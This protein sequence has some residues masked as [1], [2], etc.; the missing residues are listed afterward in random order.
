MKIENCHP[1]IEDRID[2][3][4]FPLLEL[5]NKTLNLTWCLHRYVT[6]MHAQLEAASAGARSSKWVNLFQRFLS[7]SNGCFPPYSKNEHGNHIIQ[8]RTIRTPSIVQKKRW[9]QVILTKL[10][11]AFYLYYDRTLLLFSRPM[12]DKDTSALREIFQYSSLA[13]KPFD[14]WEIVTHRRPF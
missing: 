7:G 11:S 4:P 9:K 14:Q 2:L 10:S 8:T 5:L 12:R 13:E 3:R 6:S 1:K